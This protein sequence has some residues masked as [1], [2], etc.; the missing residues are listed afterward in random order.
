MKRPVL[1]SRKSVVMAVIGAY[2]GGREYASADLGMPLKKFD[3]QAYENAGSRP[4]A[5]EHIHRLEQVAG[6]TFL[7]DY[8]ASMYGGM[9]VPLCLPETLDN[10]ELYSRSLKASAKRGKV[11]QIMAAAL[12]DGIIENVKPTRL[13]PPLSRTCLPVTPRYSRLSSSTARE[14]SSEY[15]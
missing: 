9:F 12:D 6:T 4:L 2:P 5:D 7:A 11:D 10:V 14:L 3:N 15:L 1:D 13:F 8:I